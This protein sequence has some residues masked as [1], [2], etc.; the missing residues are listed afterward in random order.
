MITLIH[1]DDIVSSR[2]YF[3]SLQ[4]TDAQLFDG[5][6]I[7]NQLLIETLQTT[8]LFGSEKQILLENFFSK[9]KASKEMDLIIET[10]VSHQANAE[11]ILWES[12]EIGKKS[13]GNL[14]HAVIKS[15]TLPKSLFSFLDAIKPNNTEELL[16]LYRK[17]REQTDPEMVLVMLF[18]QI[19]ILLALTDENA[20]ETIDEVKR[21]QPWQKKKLQG[22][23]RLFSQEKL[24]QLHK[25]L[26]HL[27]IGSKTGG[28]SLPLS[29]SIDFFL[30]NI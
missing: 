2:T 18:R 8:D 27:E 3:K 4:K 22:Q 9:R 16:L 17:T 5:E 7:T 26:V 14:S 25:N 20:P 12:K 30:L 23:V 1:G 10:I 15:Y 19:R 11:I 21:M 13:L 29:Q 6:K 24:L 28:L